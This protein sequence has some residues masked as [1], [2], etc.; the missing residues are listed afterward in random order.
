MDGV[1]RCRLEFLTL[2]GPVQNQPTALGT[3]LAHQTYDG[4][5]S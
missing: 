3:P 4:R 1:F 5:L 2:R